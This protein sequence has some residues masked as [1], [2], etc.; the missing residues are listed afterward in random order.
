MAVG[1][2]LNDA[3]GSGQT[4]AGH[5]RVWVH[6]SKEGKPEWVQKGQD[7]DGQKEGDQSGYAVS[8]SSDGDTVAIGAPY[9]DHNGIDAG[10]VRVW[11][12]T[13]AGSRWVQ[14][15][16]DI[17]GEAA[18]DNSGYS[19]SLSA[20][21]NT[22]AVGAF[23]NDGNG[24]S[25]G[26]VRVWTYI[27][28]VWTQRG[29]DINGEAAGDRSGWSVSLSADGDT[30][31][32]GA[33]YN[34]DGGISA[35]SVRVWM[36]A[37]GTW[38]Q[39]GGDIDGEAVADF[40]GWSISLSADGKTVA[41][42]AMGN[43]GGGSESGHVRVWTFEDGGTW[44]Q[45]GG[46]LDGEASEDQ[47]GFSVALSSDGNTVAVG[48][49]GNDGNGIRSGHVR[50]STFSEGDWESEEEDIEGEGAEDLSGFAVALSGDGDTVAVGSP[51][52]SSGHVRV[53]HSNRKGVRVEEWV[54][55]VSLVLFAVLV[56]ALVVLF[57]Y[58]ERNRKRKAANLV[59]AAETQTEE[60]AVEGKPGQDLDLQNEPDRNITVIVPQESEE[61]HNFSERP[62]S[63]PDQE[64]SVKDLEKGN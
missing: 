56:T 8:L 38:T 49:V 4:N 47:S 61:V 9:N 40:S 12:Y 10:N 54:I 58:C 16:H 53:F 5:V 51:A 30:V 57:W 18:G 14:K 44:K 11:W 2:P 48:A 34:D 59:S 19:V 43:D 21:G 60:Q 28:G 36:Y 7:I 1:A 32:I 64:R 6:L 24:I 23:G 62:V 42:G 22:V 27:R 41:V 39:K 15:G 26:H 13:G 37:G 33:P 55:P 17:E 63:A 3:S 45:K 31:A 52:T 46:D 50:V 35:G 29:G 20:D 25:S